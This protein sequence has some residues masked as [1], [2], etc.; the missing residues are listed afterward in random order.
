MYGGAFE[1]LFPGIQHRT[2]GATPMFYWL[3]CRLFS[4]WMGAVDA[5]KKT[6]T[7]VLKAGYSLMVFPGGSREIFT[8]DPESNTVTFVVKPRKGFVKLALRHGTHLVPVVVFGEKYVYSRWI[9]PE[10]LVQFCLKRFKGF[11]LLVFWGRFFTLLPYRSP[12]RVV[13]GAPIE[14]EQVDEPSAE[15]VDA[16]HAKYIEAATQL[17]H[18]HKAWG[19]GSAEKAETEELIIQ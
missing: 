16:M 8:T 15:Q 14:V 19:Y 7:R 12:L 18:A 17:W 1:R 9:A 5:G 10:W 11:P 6:A 3:F 4:M 13:Y 2:L